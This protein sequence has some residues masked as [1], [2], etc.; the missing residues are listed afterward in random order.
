MLKVFSV[1][2]LATLLTA[3]GNGSGN[4]QPAVNSYGYG[5]NSI[6][7]QGD[8]CP[9]QVAFDWNNLIAGPCNNGLVGPG[10]SVCSRGVEAFIQRNQV[11]VQGSGCALATAQTQWCP[12]YNWRAQQTFQVNMP[13][14]QSI[15]TQNG[16]PS[17]FPVNG[18]PGF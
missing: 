8:F 4:D 12:G 6:A 14:L 1:L 5:Q 3:C 15:L 2:F 7:S 16:G 10:N 13:I 18:Q 9:Q 11:Y 17:S